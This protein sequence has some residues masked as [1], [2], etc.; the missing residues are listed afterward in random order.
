V[1]TEKASRQVAKTPS[2]SKQI[3]FARFAALRENFLSPYA[4]PLLLGACIWDEI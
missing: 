4:K 1:K 2:L 3:T